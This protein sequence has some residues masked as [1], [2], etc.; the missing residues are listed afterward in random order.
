MCFQRLVQGS[1][2]GAWFPQLPESI[3]WLVLQLHRIIE[4]PDVERAQEDHESPV[5]G[6]AQD[7]P[8]FSHLGAS[9][10]LFGYKEMLQESGQSHP[11][12]APL[13]GWCERTQHQA[14]SKR[15][16]LLLSLKLSG[17]GVSDVA[18]GRC[19]FG[20]PQKLL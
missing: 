5:F 11:S 4:Y 15:Q 9:F 12:R 14:G 2:R 18:P 16:E 20:A 1:R 19:I 10:S 3:Q 6:P 8:K 17:F 7:G 13:Q